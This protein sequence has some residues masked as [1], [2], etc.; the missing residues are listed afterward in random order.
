MADAPIKID[1]KKCAGCG[2]CV[3]G[4]GFGALSMVEAPGANKLGRLAQ[5]DPAACKAC[6]ACVS[7]CP[8]KA[9]TEVKREV[10]GTKGLEDY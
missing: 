2:K 9:I 6:S 1:E 3:K 10:N 5:V 7:A 4:C 8:F